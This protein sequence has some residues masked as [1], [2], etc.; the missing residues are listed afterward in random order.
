MNDEDGAGDIDDSEVVN[1]S[2]KESDDT[3]VVFLPK[4]VGQER[5]W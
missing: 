4:M 2:A 1:E 3:Q 5:G